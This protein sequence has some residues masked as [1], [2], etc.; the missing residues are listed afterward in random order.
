MANKSIIH[1]DAIDLGLQR[2]WCFDIASPKGG[3]SNT[4]IFMEQ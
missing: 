1:R 2:Q 4:R 3:F